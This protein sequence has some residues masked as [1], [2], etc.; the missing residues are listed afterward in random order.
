MAA[1]LQAS[2]GN[3]PGL[4]CALMTSLALMGFT[5][6][7]RAGSTAWRPDR[8]LASTHGVRRAGPTTG[9]R[10]ISNAC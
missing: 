3:G 9:S 1:G 6:A 10:R 2:G 8:P 4:P 5:G 7:V